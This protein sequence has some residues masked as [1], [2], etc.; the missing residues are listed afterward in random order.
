M[1]LYLVMIKDGC[2]DQD[3]ANERN[4]GVVSETRFLPH[5]FSHS[6]SI[7]RGIKALLY[8]TVHQPSEVLC[9]VRCATQKVNSYTIQMRGLYL[10]AHFTIDNLIVVSSLKGTGEG[11]HAGNVKYGIST[12]TTVYQK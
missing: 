4:A 1:W 10:P 7:G 12:E 9:L 8:T 6:F 2:E 3:C 11:H 5:T